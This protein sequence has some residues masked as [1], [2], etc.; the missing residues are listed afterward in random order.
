MKREK[1]KSMFWEFLANIKII[2]M[3]SSNKCTHWAQLMY[4]PIDVQVWEFFSIGLD[5]HWR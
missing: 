2:G 3:N 4:T 1:T 5:S